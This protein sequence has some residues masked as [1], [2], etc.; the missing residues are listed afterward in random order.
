MLAAV[1]RERDL[2]V[3]DDNDLV[4]DAATLGSLGSA[5][6]LDVRWSVLTKYGMVIRERPLVGP[7]GLPG[8]CI[9]TSTALLCVRDRKV[10]VG[11]LSFMNWSCSCTLGFLCWNSVP[12]LTRC[13]ATPSPTLLVRR[14]AVAPR[15]AWAVTGCNARAAIIADDSRTGARAYVAS[16]GL[17]SGGSARPDG[18]SISSPASKVSP[19]PR[20]G[21]FA[22][23]RPQV[24]EAGPLR[25][26]VGTNASRQ[27]RPIARRRMSAVSR[28]SPKV[29]P[30]RPGPR[31]S[32]PRS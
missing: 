25:T 1:D 30:S 5:S 15:V 4:L 6:E 29:V 14:T 20:Y 2:L 10:T 32:C 8:P 17:L 3:V 13:A 24:P 16:G 31:R 12:P 22:D 19:A 18:R 23:V 7:A 9:C 21:A 28:S 26:A 27:G 11:I